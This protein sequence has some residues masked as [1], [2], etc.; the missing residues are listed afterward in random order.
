VSSIGALITEVFEWVANLPS[1][2]WGYLLSQISGLINGIPCNLPSLQGLYDGL[3]L[4]L[5]NILA[6][7]GFPEAVTI[8]GSALLIKTVLRLIPFVGLGR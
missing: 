3:P 1:Q 7:V 2:I 8:L 6:L 5:L 4:D